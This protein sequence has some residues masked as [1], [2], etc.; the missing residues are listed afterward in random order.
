M[1]NRF[2]QTGIAFFCILVLA[3][4]SSITTLEAATL[5]AV[6]VGDTNDKALGKGMKINIENMHDELSKAADLTGLELN[7]VMKYGKSTKRDQVIKQ[8]EELEVGPDDV[9]IAFFSMHGYRTHSKDTQW[10]SLFFGQDL[11]G[12]D[13]DYIVNSISQKNPRLLI[14]LADSCNIYASGIN[15][16]HAPS[17]LAAS[18]SINNYEKRNYKKLF[19]DSSGTIIASGS[20]PGTPAWG[21]NKLGSFMTIGLLESLQDV[22]KKKANAS[23]EN[24][25]SQLEVRVDTYMKRYATKKIQT[26]QYVIDLNK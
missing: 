9:V 14:A 21:V 18:F 1:L 2:K 24:V 23:W 20:L 4:S 8:I 25:F 6:L 3:I 13:L 11:T 22:V 5:H 10:P 26:P 17:A 16:L 7:V 15:T 19:L 12:V